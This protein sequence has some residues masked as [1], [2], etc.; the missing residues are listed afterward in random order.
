[1]CAVY[2]RAIRARTRRLEAMSPPHADGIHEFLVAGRSVASPPLAPRPLV[3][4]RAGGEDAVLF[5]CVVLRFAVSGRPVASEAPESDGKVF[6]DV[7]LVGRAQE[8]LNYA[9][10]LEPWLHRCSRCLVPGGSGLIFAAG[11][12]ANAR[13]WRERRR[14]DPT[15]RREEAQWGTHRG[16][17]SG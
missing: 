17:H 11:S 13:S 1:M 6:M 10:R 3:G 7:N 8:T 9:T 15:A 16:A 2:A 4:L 14:R 12:K 5:K